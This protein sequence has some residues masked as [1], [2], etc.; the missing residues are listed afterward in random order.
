MTQQ[1]DSVTID[2]GPAPVPCSSPHELKARMLEDYTN[3]AGL[4]G[5]PREPEAIERL[6]LHD[7]ALADAF[8][9]E[10][11]PQRKGPVPTQADYAAKRAKASAAVAEQ[12]DGK[13]SLHVGGAPTEWG[14]TLDLPPEIEN[15]EKW[16]LAKGRIA[17]VM[18]GASPNVRRF[19][20]GTLDLKGMTKD[21]N[22]PAGAE[23]YLS[24]W[25]DMDFRYA[26]I[27]REYNRYYGM[28]HRD[29]SLKFVAD[30]M[31]ICDSSTGTSMGTWFTP[32]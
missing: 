19:P 11:G 1:D 10:E 2:V 8:N 6:V 29:A 12:T 4:P 18:Q 21:A 15:S 32:K 16:L 23:R 26:W 20:D 28:S 22:Y 5:M 3:R 7:L 14:P 24:N 17:R 27:T 31:A 9:R 30:T 13:G 25:I